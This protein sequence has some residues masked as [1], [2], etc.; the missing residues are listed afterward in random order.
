MSSPELPYK[1]ELT[2][3]G[4]AIEGILRRFFGLVVSGPRGAL[5]SRAREEGILTMASTGLAL[6]SRGIDRSRRFL[7]GFG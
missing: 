4:P 3:E 1:P 7:I 2:I 6:G 5:T